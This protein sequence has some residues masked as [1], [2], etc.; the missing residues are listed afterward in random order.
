M[1]KWWESDPEERY[2]MEIIRRPLSD[3]GHRLRAHQLNKAGHVEGYRMLVCDVRAGD[4]VAHW[5][6]ERPGEPGIVGWSVGT[7]VHSVGEGPD[8]DGRVGPTWE[9]PLSDFTRLGKDLTLSRVRQAEYRVLDIY[10][11]LD[12]RYGR[13]LYFPFIEGHPTMPVVGYLTK[14]PVEFVRLFPELSPLL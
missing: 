4:V 6:T 1:R 14:L 2:W 11:R 10:R 12:E 7:G 8:R 3:I 5:W 9:T 13:P